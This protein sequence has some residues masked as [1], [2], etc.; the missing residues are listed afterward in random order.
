MKGSGET[1]RIKLLSIPQTLQRRKE[2][3]KEY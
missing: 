1:S 2:E 3:M